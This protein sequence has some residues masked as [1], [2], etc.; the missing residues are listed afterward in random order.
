[1]YHVRGVDIN[2]PWEGQRRYS[3]FYALYDVLL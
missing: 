1:M 2:G 3:H